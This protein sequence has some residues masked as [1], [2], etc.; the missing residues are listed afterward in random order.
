MQKQKTRLIVIA[1]PQ[2]AGKS[3]ALKLIK[4]HFPQLPIIDEVNQYSIISKSHRGGAYVNLETEYKILNEDIKTIQNIK[5]NGI[6]Y[7]M[8]TGILH[9]SYLERLSNAKITDGFYKKYISAHNNLYPIIFFIDTKPQ[10]SWK[11]RRPTYLKRIKANNIA[12]PKEKQIA[13]KKYRQI[14]NELYPLWLKYYHKV[15]FEKYMIKNS[16]K[17]YSVFK[18]ELLDLVHKLSV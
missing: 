9:L 3:T 15:P 6:I 14:I 1:G 13:L 18:K 10:I 11:R 5:R 8:E 12:D 16:Y 2:S 17:S 7:I 4:S